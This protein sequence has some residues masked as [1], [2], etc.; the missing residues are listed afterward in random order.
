[1]DG[2]TMKMEMRA[3]AWLVCVSFVLLLF[4]SLGLCGEFWLLKHGSVTLLRGCWPP[5]LLVDVPIILDH[6]DEEQ[7]SR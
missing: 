3:F 5:F 2:R 7:Q 4:L 6:K 1:M